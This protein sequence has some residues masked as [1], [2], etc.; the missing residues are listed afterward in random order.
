MTTLFKIGNNFN[1]KNMKK[2]QNFLLFFLIFNMLEESTTEAPGP[3][4]GRSR[5]LYCGGSLKPDRDPPFS[6]STCKFAL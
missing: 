6:S 3:G 1:I 2:R 4:F 5:L